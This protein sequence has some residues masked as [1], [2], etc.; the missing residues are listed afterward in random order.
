MTVKR[1]AI[2][3]HR[4]AGLSNEPRSIQEKLGDS[5]SYI[6][7]FTEKL[8]EQQ[9]NFLAGLVLGTMQRRK[10]DEQRE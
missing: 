6:G 7:E 5:I 4:R 8:T 10:D 1:P 9:L 3:F 2:H